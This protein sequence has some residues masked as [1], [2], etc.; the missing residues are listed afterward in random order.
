MYIDEWAQLFVG[1]KKP[2]GAA[3]P[4]LPPWMR[5]ERKTKPSTGASTSVFWPPLISSQC[6]RHIPNCQKHYYAGAPLV[7]MNVFIFEKIRVSFGLLLVDAVTRR[8]IYIMQTHR[9]PCA[10]WPRH[11]HRSRNG[12]DLYKNRRYQ[13]VLPCHICSSLLEL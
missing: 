3:I 11:L 10:T 8:F 2:G 12:F 7:L 4:A 6:R 1:R 13:F 9:L 5:C